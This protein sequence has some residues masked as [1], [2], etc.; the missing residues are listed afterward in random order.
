MRHE[1]FGFSCA[2]AGAANAP[3]ATAPAPVAP[4]FLI[5]E[6]R[7]IKNLPYRW[8]CAAKLFPTR[9]NGDEL[10][11]QPFAFQALV[12]ETLASRQQCGT[13]GLSIKISSLADL[14]EGR[15]PLPQFGQPLRR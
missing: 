15:R 13:G 1:I 7:S 3:A 12:Y 4:A 6:R 9:R 10:S 8:Q 14:R 5:N 2:I 11:M